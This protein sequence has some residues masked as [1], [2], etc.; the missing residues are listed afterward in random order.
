MGDFYHL[1][2]ADFR[3][4]FA[5]LFRF[6]NEVG[7]GGWVFSRPMGR[8]QAPARCWH[9]WMGWWA[10]GFPGSVPLAGRGPA[11]ESTGYLEQPGRGRIL[12]GCRS[13]GA[14]RDWASPWQDGLRAG[15]SGKGQ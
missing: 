3:W 10:Q 14:A 1:H 12:A 2:I 15:T 4:W 6:G 5:F 11:R 8:L 7:V 9:G 13:L